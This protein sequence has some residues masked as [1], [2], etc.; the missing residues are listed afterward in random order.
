MPTFNTYNP[1]DA[2]NIFTKN[3]GG[4]T[5]GYIYPSTGNWPEDVW[6][7]A[8]SNGYTYSCWSVPTNNYSATQALSD[9]LLSPGV[10]A[11]SS[12]TIVYTNA[13]KG[14][15]HASGNITILT[16]SRSS[17]SSTVNGGAN[18]ENRRGGGGTETVYFWNKA[19]GQRM[20]I[21]AGWKGTL[22]FFGQQQIGSTTQPNKSN[23]VNASRSPQNTLVKSTDNGQSVD[24]GWLATPA[25]VLVAYLFQGFGANQQQ[26][27]AAGRFFQIV[28]G[29]TTPPLPTNLTPQ[30]STIW[31][32]GTSTTVN[33]IWDKATEWFVV[34]PN[35][36][37]VIAM[38]D[39][40]IQSGP[41]PPS[42]TTYK[43]LPITI[44][45]G[46]TWKAVTTVD[47]DRMQWHIG[48]DNNDDNSYFY[49][50]NIMV[51]T[52]NGKEPVPV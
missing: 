21:P 28:G 35:A 3:A 50:C 29:T 19:T 20:K 7:K 5:S 43:Y 30:S 11:Y 16:T 42:P 49:G 40:P 14:W 2:S 34:Y 48:S 13:D 37:N 1:F 22:A 41:F 38:P 25:N 8:A 26:L 18:A 15:V 6:I 33:T 17:T 39:C 27:H 9:L 44:T 32:D 12:G 36:G 52:T 47:I 45:G 46:Y 31:S 24:Y 23:I 4:V 51:I 10:G